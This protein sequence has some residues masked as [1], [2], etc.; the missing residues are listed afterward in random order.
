MKHCVLQITM[1]G[2]KTSLSKFK[3]TEITPS[4]FFDYHGLKLEFSNRRKTRK[5][6]NTWKLNN[7]WVKPEETRSNQETRKITERNEKKT[8][9][10][11]SMG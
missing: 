4:I 8:K 3:K 6:T 1:L 2:H 11:N 5:L 10:T 7:Q 9:C